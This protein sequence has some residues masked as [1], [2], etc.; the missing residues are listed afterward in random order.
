[1]VFS[2]L[3]KLGLAAATNHSVVCRQQ[4]YG[5]TNYVSLL[6]KYL[7]PNPVRNL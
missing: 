7:N 3:D 1:M 6:D 2:W 4:F 5:N